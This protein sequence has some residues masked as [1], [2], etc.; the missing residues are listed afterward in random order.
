MGKEARKTQ[1]DRG[2]WERDG[3][4]KRVYVVGSVFGSVFGSGSGAVRECFGPECMHAQ[5]VWGLPS[6]VKDDTDARW[7]CWVGGTE[8]NAVV[9]PVKIS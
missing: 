6:L 5:R 7:M 2:L 1:G 9:A 3:L 8:G 4:V